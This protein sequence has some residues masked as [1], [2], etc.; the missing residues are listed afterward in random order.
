MRSVGAAAGPAVT[1]V[2][3]SRGLY[4]WAFVLSGSVKIV[5]DLLLLWGFK[6]RKPDVERTRG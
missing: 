4:S 1:G 6:H 2:L 5:Y 3:A